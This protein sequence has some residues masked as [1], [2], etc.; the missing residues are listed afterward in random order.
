MKHKF[1]AHIFDSMHNKWYELSATCENVEEAYQR[2]YEEMNTFDILLKV[3]NEEG[4][5]V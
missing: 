2:F 5:L 4:Y 1:R 3:I